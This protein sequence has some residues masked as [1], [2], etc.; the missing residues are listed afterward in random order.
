MTS[1]AN[2]L[3]ADHFED[4]GQQRES[5]NLGMWLFLTTEVMFFGGLFAA[6]IVFR[7]IHPEAF[8]AGSRSLSVGLGTFNTFVLLVSSLTMVL[9]GH[10]AQVGNARNVFRCL[11][12]TLVLGLVFLGVKVVEYGEKLQQGYF[13]H[14]NFVFQGEVWPEVGLFFWLYF[15]MTGMH[16]IH[17]I[18]GMAIIVVMM[19]FAWKG[20][21]VNGDYMPVEMMGYYWHFV[22]IVWVFLFP[23]LYLIDRV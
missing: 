2:S 16:A 19:V 4:I 17:M 11:G 21:Y 18:I 8:D 1:K 6:Y 14:Q 12:A 3:V 23:L 5:A 20:R 15:G 9:A 13:P 22:D 10:A 7:G